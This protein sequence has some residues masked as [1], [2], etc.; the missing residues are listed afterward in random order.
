MQDRELIQRQI[1]EM[2]TEQQNLVGN[3]GW[4]QAAAPTA[5]PHP[6]LWGGVKQR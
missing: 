4:V 2:Q 5:I 3:F 1:A 6:G